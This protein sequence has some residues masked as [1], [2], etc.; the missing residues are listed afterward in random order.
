MISYDSGV[1][2]QS[3]PAG[4][5]PE[6]FDPHDGRHVYGFDN[7]GGWE[8]SL[9]AAQTWTRLNLPTST[10]SSPVVGWADHPRAYTSD[11]NLELCRFWSGVDELT[12]VLYMP[13]V[14][15]GSLP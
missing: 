11:C 5:F 1:T 7:G 4:P 8:R 6:N 10:A 3:R 13:F 14:L 15:N 9:D 2:W 12:S